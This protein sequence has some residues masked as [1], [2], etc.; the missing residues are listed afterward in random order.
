[1]TSAISRKSNW[2][3]AKAT[4]GRVSLHSA[5]AAPRNYV[6]LGIVATTAPADAL[7]EA[8][9]SLQVRFAKILS[10]ESGRARYRA[11]VALPE[12]ADAQYVIEIWER[13]KRA[14]RASFPADA[15]HAIEIIDT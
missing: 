1:M 6:G 9:K 10:S 15:A 2:P 5:G 12:D 4:N 13:V 14:L 3:L 7:L 8:T 11:E